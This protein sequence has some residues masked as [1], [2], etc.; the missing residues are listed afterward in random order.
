M[1]SPEF[2]AGKR[3]V[4]VGRLGAG[5]KDLGLPVPI[6]DEGR[7]V[8][9]A[10]VSIAGHL[11]WHVGVIPF[12]GAVGFPD[13]GAGLFVQRHMILQVG[14]VHRQDHQVFKQD[15]RRRRQDHLEDGSFSRVERR[16]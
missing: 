5:A 14:A 11:P 1:D 10:Q 4:A 6:N 3:I 7:A 13:G 9:L 8:R 16:E 2:F 15:D 12:N